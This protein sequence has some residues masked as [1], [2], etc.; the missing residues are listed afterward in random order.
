MY[1]SSIQ[2]NNCPVVLIWGL[3]SFPCVQTQSQG[4]GQISN[5]LYTAQ[6]DSITFPQL[7]RQNNDLEV[8]MYSSK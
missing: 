7:K 8:I 1:P 4:H 5:W 3:C 6:D 2:N